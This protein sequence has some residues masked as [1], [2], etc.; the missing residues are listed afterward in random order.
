[1]SSDWLI[2]PPLPLTTLTQ[3]GLQ[4]TTFNILHSTGVPDTKINPKG[5]GVFAMNIFSSLRQYAGKWNL[6]SSRAFTPEEIASV[7]SATVVASQSGNSVCFMMVGG[8]Q[9]YI[10]L[11]QNSGLGVGATVDL[12]KAQLLTLEKAG[13]ADILRVEA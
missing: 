1:M 9:T 7:A 5:I 3:L 2:T 8:G 12:H 10:P 4:H 6:K 11:S 13:E